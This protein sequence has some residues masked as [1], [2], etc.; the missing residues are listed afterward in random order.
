MSKRPRPRCVGVIPARYGSTRFPG[1]PL[2]DVAGKPMI[3][4][5][6]ERCVLAASLDDVI[7]ATDD[8]RI[9]D[10]CAEFGARVY[11]TAAEHPSGSD[12]VAEIAT[13]VGG[14]VFINI[15]GDEPLIPPAAIDALVGAFNDA[16]VMMATL[17]EPLPSEASE[18]LLSPSTCK[19]VLDREG[20]AL[21]FSRAVIPYRRNVRAATPF[22]RHVGIYGYTRDFLLL[23]TTLAPTPLEAAEGLEMLRALEHGF[24]IRV[25]T[26]KYASR[27]VDTPEDLAA[28]VASYL[29]EENGR[30]DGGKSVL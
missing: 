16:G 1:K 8:Q 14:D 2:A 6:Y 20:N 25:V 19:V 9:Y 10:V 30:C 15:Q 18:P 3:Q 7:V 27:G 11:M 29:Q 28:V 21:Y 4:R 26:G 13:L 22:Y 17:A 24:K 23:F 5:V 12:R